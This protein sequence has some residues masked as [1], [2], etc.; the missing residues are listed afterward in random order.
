M[1][2]RQNCLG[3]KL[4]GDSPHRYRPFEGVS[5]SQLPADRENRL[6]RRRIAATERV[7]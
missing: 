7:R 4:L 6:L 3:T 5:I 2:Y 1:G